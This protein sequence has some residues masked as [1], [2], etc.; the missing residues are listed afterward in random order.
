M[1]TTVQEAL[2]D[3]LAEPG[4][5]TTKHHRHPSPAARSVEPANMAIKLHKRGAKAVRRVISVL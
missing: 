4:H 2:L 1:D 5:T 3:P